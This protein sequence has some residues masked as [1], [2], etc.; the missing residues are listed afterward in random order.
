[1]DTLWLDAH[2]PEIVSIAACNRDPALH[3]AQRSGNRAHL[4]WGA[5]EHACPASA[6][7]LLIATTALEQLLDALPVMHLAIPDD[8]LSRFPSPFQRALAMLSVSFTQRQRRH[9][10]DECQ[11]IVRV[12]PDVSADDG[13]H[14][15][16]QPLPGPHRCSDVVHVYAS[17]L[18]FGMKSRWYRSCFISSVARSSTV[19]RA[20]PYRVASAANASAAHRSAR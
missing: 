11:R 1:M 2:Q 14:A 3:R 7:A 5:G 20:S 13:G 15:V 4:E 17:S 12:V 8:Q 10:E 9:S 16:Y 19:T 6:L 18:L